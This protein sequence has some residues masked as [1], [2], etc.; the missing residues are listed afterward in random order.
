MNERDT[1]DPQKLSKIYISSN[2]GGVFN[3]VQF[4]SRGIS[5]CFVTYVARLGAKLGRR[6]Q[7]YDAKHGCKHKW[8]LVAMY[9]NTIQK[10]RRFSRGIYLCARTKLKTI[11][12][13]NDETCRTKSFL[14]SRLKYDDYSKDLLKYL[15]TELK[16]Q[17]LIKIYISVHLSISKFVSDRCRHTCHISR[18]GYLI[19]LSFGADIADLF[20]R[21]IN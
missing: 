15:S 16:S 3:P 19:S 14:A 1:S 13:H 10:R 7:P 9:N 17:L 11:S 2:H 12:R 8:K 18:S 20:Y 6:V 5:R 4:S 21:L